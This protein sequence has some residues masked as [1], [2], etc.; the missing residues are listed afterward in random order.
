[1]GYRKNLGQ[2]NFQFLEIEADDDE[3]YDIV[4]DFMKVVDFVDSL[5]RQSSGK[6]VNVMFHCYQ[7]VNRSGSVLAAFLTQYKMKAGPWSLR[8]SIDHI[9]SRRFPFLS[10]VHFR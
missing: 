9:S 10:N 2:K 1:M 3:E 7:G 4:A 5:P 8:D 6:S